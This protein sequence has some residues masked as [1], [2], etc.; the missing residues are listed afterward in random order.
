MMKFWN[1]PLLTTGGF[2]N[3]F[4][5]DK[6]DPKSKYFLLVRTGTLAFQALAD[7]VV[8]VLNR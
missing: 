6:R 4:S 2:T 1:A 3:D 5:M 7:M 8:S